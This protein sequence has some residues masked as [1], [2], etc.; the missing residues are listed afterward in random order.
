MKIYSMTAT[1]GKLENQTLT[2]ESGLNVIHAPNEWGKSTWCAFLV[3]MLYGLDTG[4]RS[5]KAFLADK[6]RYAPW[7]GS[8]M[9]G[10]IDLCW[11]D[12]NITI[13]R[14][15]KGRTPMG[16]FRAYETESGMAVPELTA[17]TCGEVLLGVERSVFLRSGFLRLTDLPVTED[18]SLRRRLNSLVTTGDES[19]AADELAQKL[20]ELKNKCRFN[21]T[22]LIPAAEAEEKALESKLQ[23]LQQLQE[24]TQQVLAQQQELTLRISLLENHQ[25]ALDYAA[26]EEQ[27]RHIL[28]AQ[29][30]REEAK[31][32][33]Q[34]QQQECADLPEETQAK[35][36]TERLHQLHQQSMEL[37]LEKQMLPTAPQQPTAPKC[38]E[39]MTGAEAIAQVQL[40]AEAVKRGQ[41]KGGLLKITAYLL[42][43]L[44]LVATVVLLFVKPVLCIASCICVAFG[45]VLLSRTGKKQKNALVERYGKLP[46]EQ[47]LPMAEQ[48]AAEQEQYLRALYQYEEKLQSLQ[49]RRQ[50]LAAQ[51]LELTQGTP[52]GQC[53]G[54]WEE[55]RRQWQSL[56]DAKK[57]Y[58][59]AEAYAETVAAMARPVQKPEQPDELTFSSAETNRMLQQSREEQHR[60]QQNLGIYRGKMELLGQEDAL[61]NQLKQVQQRLDR[62][63]QTYGAL[64]LAQSTLAAA[65]TELQRRFAPQIAQQAQEIFGKLTHGRYDRLTMAQDLSLSAGAEQESVLRTAQWRS[66][67]TIDQMYLALRLAVAKALIPQSPMILDD[68]L[69]RFDDVRHAAAMELLKQEAL[70]R[71]IILFT[72]QSR[73]TQKRKSG[74]ESATPHFLM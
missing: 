68:A 46:A 15:T 22:G 28:Q 18:D 3:N 63:N 36:V 11:Q 62:L 23:Q 50:Q 17:T 61:Q 33:L 29:I 34:R 19:D 27:N 71:Q 35:A 72:C 4:A 25:K 14:W 73:E 8:P 13:E 16:E 64:E 2:L 65:T 6:E 21:R 41:N 53:I 47:W 40:D 26:A 45:G 43:A 70:Q 51:I 69:V 58:E 54:R 38:F 31:S 10:R 44:G 52:I 60:L 12:R 55:I 7:S 24:S 67:G 1:F 37:D 30:S 42:L 59:G 20:K 57:G 56:S 39:G 74:I 66:E 5:K 32:R 9:S 48:Y 49:D